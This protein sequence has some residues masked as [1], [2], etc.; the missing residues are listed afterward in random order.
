ML[1]LLG[2]S[3]IR[4]PPSPFSSLG[5]PS[6]S[7]TKLAV[8]AFRPLCQT[9]SCS[10]PVPEGRPQLPA[11]KSQQPPRPCPASFVLAARTR[12]P[13]CGLSG[14]CKMSAGA[15]SPCMAPHH[16]PGPAF[17]HSAQGSSP[18]ASPLPAPPMPASHCELR[19]H[20]KRVCLAKSCLFSTATLQ[21]RRLLLPASPWKPPST[22]PAGLCMS[23][24]HFVHM[25][26]TRPGT[27]CPHYSILVSLCPRGWGLCLCRL[28]PWYRVPCWHIRYL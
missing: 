25:V 13:C 23:P 9:S 2:G 22:L 1:H 24:Q 7:V 6:Q 5:E 17:H 11:G 3:Q 19:Q 10:L 4:V 26:L 8:S 28:C 14:L 16:V 21:C 15:L 27:L 18:L 12:L 20:Q